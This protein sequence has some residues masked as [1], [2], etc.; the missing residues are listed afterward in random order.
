MM[1][2]KRLINGV[3]ERNLAE[4]VGYGLVAPYVIYSIIFW[5]YP[6]LWGLILSLIH[7]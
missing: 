6:F 2:L 3:K 7:I 5:V 1:Q 4:L